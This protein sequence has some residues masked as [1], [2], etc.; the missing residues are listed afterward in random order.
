M[1]VRLNDDTVGT[2]DSDALNGQS[3]ED[4]VGKTVS[5]RLHDENG[6]LIEICGILDEVLESDPA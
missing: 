3:V 4:F 2:I 6:N 1:K 5:V